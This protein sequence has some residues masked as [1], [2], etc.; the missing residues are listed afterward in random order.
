MKKAFLPN[1]TMQQKLLVVATAHVAEELS[2]E[3]I[4]LAWQ[5]LREKM[6]TPDPDNPN[7]W[8]VWIDGHKLWGILDEK[9]GPNGEDV[10][11]ILFPEDY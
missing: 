11:T 4:N 8:V 2:L 5:Q 10:F 7:L 6:K 1:R 9:A 3:Q